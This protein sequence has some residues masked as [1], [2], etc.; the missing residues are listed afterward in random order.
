M[1]ES[2][3]PFLCLA[4][5]LS[6]IP[7]DGQTVAWGTSVNFSPLS[8]NSDGSVDNE[9]NTWSIGWFNDGFEPNVDNYLE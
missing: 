4:L 1:T 9:L 6:A 3:L 8:F 5:G 2:K 7:A